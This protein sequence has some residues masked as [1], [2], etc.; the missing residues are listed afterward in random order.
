MKREF[1]IRFLKSV[2]LQPEHYLL[3]IGCGT[4][5]GGLPIIK[6][7]Q[8]GHYYGT[9]VRSEVLKE[10][11]KELQQA[12]IDKAP[13]LVLSMDISSL[14]LKRKFDFI[15]AYSVLIHLSDDI[16]NDVLHFAQGHLAQTG[17]F[18]VNANIGERK[19]GY[20]HQGFP[21]VWRSV[22]FYQQ[23]AT[24]AGLEVTDL[25][26]VKALGFGSG[27]KDHDQQHILRFKAR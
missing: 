19:N 10:A 20:W 22:D 12:N 26:T 11:H 27:R 25:G 15:W 23:E 21:L 17:Q 3:D 18:F 1:Q 24:R 14:D 8:R 6:Y 4:L 9:E 13:T 7:L 5:R 16:L 2:G